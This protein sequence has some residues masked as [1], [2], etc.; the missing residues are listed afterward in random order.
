MNPYRPQHGSARPVPPNVAP[1]APAWPT[2]PTPSAPAGNG[3]AQGPRW[4]AT[5]GIAVAVV[6]GAIGLVLGVLGYAG[7]GAD[8]S[9]RADHRDQATIDAQACATASSARRVVNGSSAVAF[10]KAAEQTDKS[11]AASNMHFAVFT[12]QSQIP[13]TSKEISDAMSAWVT[14]AH[15]YVEAFSVSMSDQAP[16]LKAAQD[17]MLKA[18]KLSTD[19]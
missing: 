6:L 15:K 12:V 2:P 17:T 11:V 10:N 1:S 18:C 19:N 9:T 8:S 3:A 13:G 14:Q 5:A 7:G 4:L 16:A